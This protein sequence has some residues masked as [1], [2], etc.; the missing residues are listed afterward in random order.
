[1]IVRITATVI[2][3]S[4]ISTSAFAGTLV[5]NTTNNKVSVGQGYTD[6]SSVRNST[7]NQDNFSQSL[8]MESEAPNASA[9]VTFQNGQVFGNAWG[10][11]NPTNPDPVAISSYATQRE[12]VSFTQQDNAKGYEQY[13]FVEN[14]YSHSV[15]SDSTF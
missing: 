7:G 11:T 6:F 8:K 2:G 3:L 5:T 4:L 14:G 9:S 13:N 12:T 15:S 1:M 10:T